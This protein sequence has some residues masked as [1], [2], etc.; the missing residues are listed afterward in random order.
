MLMHYF[1]CSGGMG[2]DLTKSVSDTLRRPCVFASCGICGSRSAFHCVRSAKGRRTIFHTQVRLV[3]IP[4]KACQ[5]TLRRTFVFSSIGI[6]G[7]HSAFRCIRATKCRRAILHARLGPVRISQKIGI[8]GSRS[9][10]WCVC[11]TK[12]RRPLFFM[13]GGTDSDSTKSAP[14]HVTPNLCFCIRWDMWVT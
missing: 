6:F 1:S 7:S 11:A 4:Q 3:Q 9:A 2:I 12:G 5:D 10:F 14:G 8:C 13:L